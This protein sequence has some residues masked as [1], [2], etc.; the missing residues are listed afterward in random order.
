MKYNKLIILALFSCSV[1][2]TTNSSVTVS[3]AQ[4]DTTYQYSVTQ[5]AI[6][7]VNAL[8]TDSSHTTL[9][10]QTTQETIKEARELVLKAAGKCDAHT[11]SNLCTLCNKAEKLLLQTTQTEDPAVVKAVAAVDAL[12]TDSTHTTLATNTTQETIKEARELVLKAAGKCNITTLSILCSQ[13]DD[14]L[15]QSKKNSQAPSIN[16]TKYVIGSTSI[17]GT[18]TGD[19]VKAQLIIDN[20]IISAG[21]T[22]KDG[23]FSYY[24]NNGKINKNKKISMKFY[25]SQN[26]SILQD[27]N[28]QGK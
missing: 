13:A 23:K 2:L 22:F 17:T 20:K 7:A 11:L 9:S 27:V 8:Y 19:I 3:A 21:G 5:K 18:Y 4:V 14:L 26:N 15:L 28:I 24:V 16:S 25:D 10:T 6:D 1:I 12:F